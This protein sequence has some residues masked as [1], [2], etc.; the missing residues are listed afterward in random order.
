MKHLDPSILTAGI[1][2]SAVRAEPMTTAEIDAHPD[3]ARIWATV[4]AIRDI[5]EQE[6]EAEVEARLEEEGEE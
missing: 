2:T 6:V 3:S 4:Q 5:M 1:P